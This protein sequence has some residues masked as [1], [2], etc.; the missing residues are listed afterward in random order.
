MLFNPLRLLISGLITLAV[1]GFV[2]SKALDA[3]DQADDALEEA[4]ASASDEGSLL[5]GPALAD[6]LAKLKEE[7]GGAKDVLRIT[8]YPSYV[9]AEVSTGSEDDAKGYKVQKDGDVVPFGVTLTGPGKLADNVFPLA[10]VDP[11]ALDTIIAGV[12]KRDA[13]LGL[14]DV[15]HALAG[16][17]PVSGKADWKVYFG[18]AAYYTANLDGSNLREGGAA[19]SQTATQ[20]DD[21]VSDAKK[22]TDCLAKAAGDVEAVQACTS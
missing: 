6:A 4:N 3:F 9:S 8:V 21:A 13:S 15:S 14:D 16:I 2:G 5:R 22:I 10:D 17:D 12:T 7:D 20:A 19:P 1:F 11:K 18:G